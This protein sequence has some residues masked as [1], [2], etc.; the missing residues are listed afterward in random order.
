MEIPGWTKD[1]ILRV[2]QLNKKHGDNHLPKTKPEDDSPT[3]WFYERFIHIFEGDTDF[4]FDDFEEQDFRSID[5]QELKIVVQK[6]NGEEAEEYDEENSSENQKKSNMQLVRDF[7]IDRFG[8]DFDIP[9]PEEMFQ[10]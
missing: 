9:D 4:S 6:L 8:K 3:W 10:S 2:E 1:D 7:L 5:W